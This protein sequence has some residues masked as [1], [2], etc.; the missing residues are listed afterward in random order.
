MTAFI[1]C[2]HHTTTVLGASLDDGA[3]KNLRRRGKKLRRPKSIL[4]FTLLEN[5]FETS[6]Q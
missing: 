6:G 4:E 2:D 1:N 3:A 5:R